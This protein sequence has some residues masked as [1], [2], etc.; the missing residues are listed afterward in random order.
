MMA[1][2][3]PSPLMQWLSQMVSLLW[4]T[5]TRFSGAHLN[6]SA[7]ML[8]VCIDCH[9]RL[10]ICLI[11]RLCTS[12]ASLSLIHLI[13]FLHIKTHTSWSGETP[14]QRYISEPRLHYR[15]LF[16]NWFSPY[17]IKKLSFSFLYSS[18]SNSAS[19]ILSFKYSLVVISFPLPSEQNY[20]NTKMIHHQ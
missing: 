20:L 13:C 9:K 5:P 15:S 10:G 3:R 6:Q 4:S 8:S 11:L 2:W 12:L 1:N 17:F 18:I 14:S 7:F 19:S 16:S